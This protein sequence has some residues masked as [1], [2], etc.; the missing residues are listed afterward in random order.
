MVSS[1]P[2]WQMH[3]TAHCEI[4]DGDM[5]LLHKQ[6]VKMHIGELSPSDYCMPAVCDKGVREFWGFLKRHSKQ[7]INFY[8]HVAD[9]KVK[10]A[11]E[12]LIGSHSMCSTAY[13]AVL[14]SSRSRW[15]SADISCLQKHSAHIAEIF[16]WLPLPRDVLLQPEGLS[17]GKVETGLAV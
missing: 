13:T 14:R 15:G 17:I 11:E 9:A 7:G 16:L 8:P 10:R 2:P 1:K 4:L 5:S 6:S 3:L 12:V